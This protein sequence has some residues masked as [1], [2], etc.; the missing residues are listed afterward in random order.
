MV[1]R[2]KSGRINI[3]NQ[4]LSAR[5]VVTPA[6]RV[7]ISDR[8]RE[9]RGPEQLVDIDEPV[10]P[11]D[12]ATAK[13]QS[14]L[15]AVAIAEPGHMTNVVSV[16]QPNTAI[17]L[18]VGCGT[19]A[20]EKLPPVFRD[21]GWREIRLDI[22]PDVQPDI[23]ANL[24]DMRVVSDG[25]VDAVYSSHNIEHLYPHEVALALGEMQRVLKP[26]GFVFLKLPDLQEV[27]RHVAEGNLTEPLYLSPM[28]PIA[29][30]DIMF[31]HRAS[32]AA[33]NAFMA[34]RTGFTA[35]TLGIALIKA[36]FAA[37][38]VQR[39]PSAFCLTA[40]AFR[41]KPIREQMA[42]AQAR[43]LPDPDQPAVLYAP[44]V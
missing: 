34:H 23:V 17:A 39:T 43:M 16:E 32:L 28:G 8:A 33:G 9:T 5:S 11:P 4:S 25:A 14:V 3:M 1:P 38:M 18:H 22:D 36:G 35:D 12:V 21:A 10:H 19:Y 40:V 44:A 15:G 20:R 24:I 2:I 31:G 37:A 26:T 7:L 41:N 27:A 42:T 30:L 29:A 13:A 6:D